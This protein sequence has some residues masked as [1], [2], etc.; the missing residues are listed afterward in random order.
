M[1]GIE[2]EVGSG[3]GDDEYVGNV[4]EVTNDEFGMRMV[5]T[6]I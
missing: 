5:M 3:V 2:L 1:F 6:K 4:H